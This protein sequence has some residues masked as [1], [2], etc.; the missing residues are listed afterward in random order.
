[1]RLSRLVYCSMEHDNMNESD[2]MEILKVAI[3]RNN[4]N[5]ITGILAY[6]NCRF[7]QLLEGPRQEVNETYARISKDDRHN[8]V[9]LIDFREVESRMFS[10][11]SMRILSI[12]ENAVNRKAIYKYN[13]S[14]KFLPETLTVT[15]AVGLLSELAEHD[16]VQNLSPRIVAGD[17]VRSSRQ[18]ACS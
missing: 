18:F 13:G 17:Q 3:D 11:W 4:A 1:M 8:R 14:K 12:Q 16:V 7:L 9:Q 2:L 6:G 5:G 10:E 15:Q